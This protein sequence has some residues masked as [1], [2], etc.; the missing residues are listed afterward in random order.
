MTT[1]ES[2]VIEAKLLTKT[3]RKG[4]VEAVRGIDLTV[5]RGVCFG[6]LGPNGAGKSTTLEML[7]GILEPTSGSLRIFG[8]DY[9]TSDR[10]IRKRVGGILQETEFYGR[11][12]VRELLELFAS[13]YDAAASVDAI[14]S[15]LDLSAV[16]G[17]FV[18]NLSGGQ[19][20]RAFLATALVGEPELLFLDEP[21][22]GLDPAARR[23]FWS[24]IKSLKAR[25]RTI[26]LSTHYMEEAEAL[27]DDLVI[28][29]SGTIIERGHP[30]A[31]IDRVM[32]G[33]EVP[34]R[35]RRATLNDVFLT[36]TGRP[37]ETDDLPEVK[38]AA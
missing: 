14:A 6:L 7:Q 10:A 9:K 33:R 27:A 12:R 11:T 26:V 16:M 38:G 22:T 29:D 1:L 37:L 20:Q 13:L 28:V 31:I 32:Q 21:T 36:L 2:P 15:A 8:L 3:Y 17:T 23:D 35:P 4:N 34:F 25:G 30:N 19:R 5:N 24:V 18:Q